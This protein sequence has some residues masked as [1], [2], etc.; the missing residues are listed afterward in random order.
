[1]RRIETRRFEVRFQ[2][3]ASPAFRIT[4][5]VAA[6]PPQAPRSQ[7]RVGQPEYATA[8]NRI[9]RLDPADS[10]W[11]ELATLP[12]VRGQRTWIGQA[13]FGRNG[14]VVQTYADHL[15]SFND[16]TRTYFHTRD[17]G[18]TW[19]PFQL[20]PDQERGL[21]GLDA[22]GEGLLVHVDRGGKTII[23]RYALE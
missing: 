4:Q 8:D 10:N 21:L 16:Y 22:A 11:H 18:R 6:V 14:W 20:S 9:Y 13:W 12:A 2:D 3:G 5:D 1:M 7:P 23:V 15:F 17:Q 19:R